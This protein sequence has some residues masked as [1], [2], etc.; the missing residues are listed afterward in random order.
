MVSING[1][2]CIVNGRQVLDGITFTINDNEIL[3]ITG[4]A[5]S[6]KS[7]LL[8]ILSMD[9]KKYTGT[10]AIDG[11]DISSFDTN[12]LQKSIAFCAPHNTRFNP[13]STVFDRILSGRGIHKSRLRPY[14]EN[15]RELTIRYIEQ[16]ELQKY[17]GTRLKYLSG[18]MKT[19]ASLANAAISENRLLL[20]DSPEFLL[21]LRQRRN[22]SR[23]LKKYTFEDARSVVIATSD[24]DF[25]A[26]TC[27]R[28]IV[29][30]NGIIAE[31]GTHAIIDDIFLK[32]YFGIDAMVSRNIVTSMPEVHLLEN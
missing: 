2:S 9:F 32:T 16:L 15:D 28:L 4:G 22:L 1:L 17:S 30:H 7:L 26:R 12:T 5:D 31:T 25:L 21:N 29:L 27:D 8:S 13:E 20:L 23:L 18:S 14:S 24:I 19:L 11:S 3:G 10:F 6:G